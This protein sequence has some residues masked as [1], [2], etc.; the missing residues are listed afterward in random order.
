MED[1]RKR[2][3]YKLVTDADKLL[4]LTNNPL[5]HDRDIINEDIVG[6]HMIK[7][8]VTLDKPIFV[9][10]AVVDY[11]KP[12]MYHLFYTILPACPDRW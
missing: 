5:F 3:S 11:S 12:E 1:V 10:Q 9:G 2:I 4:N 6:V 8:K 7:P